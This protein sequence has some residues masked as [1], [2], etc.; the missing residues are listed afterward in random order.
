MGSSILLNLRADLPRSRALTPRPAAIEGDQSGAVEVTCSNGRE[1]ASATLAGEPRVRS[2][3]PEGSWEDPRRA[4][5]GTNDGPAAVRNL[6]RA[7]TNR[8]HRSS[9][10]ILPSHEVVTGCEVS[11]LFAAW[12]RVPVRRTARPAGDHICPFERKLAPSC[13]RSLVDWAQGEKHRSPDRLDM[14]ARWLATF[15][16]PDQVHWLPSPSSTS[17]VELNSRAGPPFCVFTECSTR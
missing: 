10:S 14:A 4:S 11:D 3:P 1:T 5:L 2:V 8:F 16:V 17:I 15:A 7:N 9:P 6:G 12:S 13:T